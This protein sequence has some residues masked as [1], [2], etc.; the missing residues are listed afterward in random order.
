MSS[1]YIEINTDIRLFPQPTSIDLA[2]FSDLSIGDLHS[3]A[4]KMMN[5]LVHYRYLELSE[6]AYLRFAALYQQ[7]AWTQNDLHEM[8]TIIDAIKPNSSTLPHLRFLGD[9]LADRG[10]ND[11]FIL[12]LLEKLHKSDISFEII[13]SNHDA[14]FIDCYEKDLDYNNVHYGKKQ[15]R[16]ACNLQNLLDEHFIDYQTVDALVQTHYLPFLKALSYSLNDT[17]DT[18]RIYSHAPIGMQTLCAIANTLHLDYIDHDATHLAHTIEQINTIFTKHYAQKKRLCSLLNLDNIAPHLLSYGPLD[19]MLY[20]FAFLMH[21]HCHD[22]LETLPWT[23]FVHA[24]TGQPAFTQQKIC[25]NNALGISD[26]QPMGNYNVLLT[27]EKRHPTML[28]ALDTEADALFSSTALLHH[29]P[30]STTAASTNTKSNLTDNV[31][32]T[33][34]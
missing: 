32:C 17:E 9:M 2:C 29:Y 14:D 22:A 5:F 33:L 30:A 8:E 23:R 25:L 16:S 13:I 4:L 6:Q 21:N 12:K 27:N 1:N 15:G 24:H 10:K 19:P 26:T 3:N 28:P 34:I 31:F 11:Y 18:I 7:S 20:P